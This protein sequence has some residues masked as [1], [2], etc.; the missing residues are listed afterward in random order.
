MALVVI[1]V[2]CGPVAGGAEVDVSLLAPPPQ[3]GP[4]VV[5]ASFDL[6]DINEVNDGTETFEFTGALTL[7]WRDP[8]LAFDPAVAGVAV[9][10]YQGDYQFNELAAGWYPQVV[11]ANVAGLYQQTGVVL[12][13]QPDGTS[14]VTQ[15][16]NA[17]AETEFDM[18]RFPFDGQRLQA[19]F[20]IL[21]FDRDQVVLQIDSESAGGLAA[22]RVAQWTIGKATVSVRDQATSAGG[23]SARVSALV[24]SVDVQRESWFV[25]RLI[26]VPLVVIVLLSFSVFWMDR[27]SLGD[28]VSVSFIGILTVVAYQLVTSDQLPHISYVT[29]IHGFL[30]LSFLTM[31]ATVVINLVVGTLD[32]RGRSELGD[33]IDRRCRWIFPLVYFVLIWLMLG[34]ELTLL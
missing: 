7:R 12:R 21:G 16:I 34:L 22:V 20:E 1:L 23:R 33:R 30:N 15:T 17:A 26:V 19:V 3:A 5:R 18:R 11:L 24:L 8:R 2:C 29:L 6:F 9:K 27:S 14:T 13:V 4:V 25:R 31:C 10:I 28:R 32:R